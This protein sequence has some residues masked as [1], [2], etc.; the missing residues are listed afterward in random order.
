M[1]F[2]ELLLAVLAGQKRIFGEDLDAALDT[3]RC[4]LGL[5]HGDEHAAFVWEWEHKP[6]EALW[7]CWTPDGAMRFESLRH[8]ETEGGSDGDACTLYRGHAREHSWNVVDPATEAF[9]R[10]V[11]AENAGLLAWLARKRE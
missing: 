7:A 5:W 1:P 4:E 2:T 11:L 3:A 10:R 8:C 9:R 6:S